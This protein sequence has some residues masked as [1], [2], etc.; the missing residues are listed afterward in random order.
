MGRD[1]GYDCVPLE[2]AEKLKSE[3]QRLWGDLGLHFSQFN[4]FDRLL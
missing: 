4:L 1:L 3:G 2:C